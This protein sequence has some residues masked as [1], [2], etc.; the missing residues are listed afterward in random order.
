MERDAGS[1]LIVDDEAS[2]LD[3]L[4]LLFAAGGLRGRRPRARSSEARGAAR[5]ATSFDLVLC[6]IMMPD[7]NGLDLLREIKAA[8][9]AH[10]RSIMMTAYTSTKIGDRGDEARRLRL[11]LQAVRRRR[12]QGRASQKA[13]EKTELC[14][15]EPLPARA[16]SSSATP[17][18][19]SSAGA[20]GCRRSSRLIERVARTSSTV[21]I[22]G[23]SGTGKELIARAIHFSSPRS[24]QR[25]LSVNCGAMPEN[26]LES[27]LFGHERGAFTGA[28]REKKGLF[29]EADGGTLFLDEIGEM[30][31]A[32]AGEA[33]ARPAGEGGA[34][35]RRQPRRSRST[36]A[37]SPPP[38]R[39]STSTIAA[40]RAS[41]RTSTTASTSSRSSCRR[42]ASG[43][44]TSR[45][46]S[47]TSSS[48]Y[49][50]RDGAAAASASRSR[51]C[52]C[53][54]ATT[55]RATC[56]SSRT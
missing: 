14:R 21:L 45:C 50:A 31:P 7:G 3:F 41:A 9:R 22:H 26:L 37:S 1:L 12:A 20:R 27:E 24:T 34:Q 16:S 10:R 6:D 4:S 43:A 55:G 19:T 52:A 17:S 13:L 56:A 28:V 39:T 29:Q 25:F 35:G 42:C 2:L 44:R 30:T 53:S 11:R 18:T 48:K 38:T 5:R 36:C 49:S 46:W 15:R 54:R 51:R 47:T 8:E 23:E 33:A 40:R 32:D